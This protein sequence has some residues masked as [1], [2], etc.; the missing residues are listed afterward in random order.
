M[1]RDNE[2]K[3]FP[4]Y[5]KGLGVNRITFYNR[6]NGKDSASITLDG[7]E[8]ENWSKGKFKVELCLDWIHEL[9]HKLR[10]IHDHNN[11]IPKGLEKVI[12][13]L[14]ADVPLT[15]KDREILYKEEVGAAQYWEVIIK[16]VDVRIKP[17]R[18][19]AQREFDLW[20][21]E[22][23]MKTGEWPK[24]KE[25]VQKWKEIKTKWKTKLS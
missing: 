6:T 22:V 12:D 7:T 4:Q 13:K 10:R 21:Y 5:A 15:Y 18:I 1:V 8:F 24:S 3:R 9:G 2:L 23:F 19:E 20:I 14:N 17:Y 25:K 16:D 11:K